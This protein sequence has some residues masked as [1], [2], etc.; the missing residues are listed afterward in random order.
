MVKPPD[1]FILFYNGGTES[2]FYRAVRL[3]T[4][5]EPGP[6]GRPIV[7]DDGRIEYPE[8]DPPDID[9]YERDG[10]TFRPIWPSCRWRALT[11]TTPN[12][13]FAISSSCQNPLSARHLKH[14]PPAD[15]HKC[16]LRVPIPKP[17]SR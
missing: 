8:G 17:I 9:G 14:A 12:G 6:C 13:C 7:H 11:V 4:P 3:A 5:I 10:R 1:S 16:E 15:C 2:A